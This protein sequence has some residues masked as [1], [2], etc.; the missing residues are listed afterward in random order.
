M[1][2][3][4]ARLFFVVVSYVCLAPSAASAS[5]ILFSIDRLDDFLIPAAEFGT[6]IEVEI[7]APGVT[8][9]AV[10][11][12]TLSV[13]MEQTDDGVWEEAG[14]NI[15]TSLAALESTVS[16][17][18]TIVVTG[19]ADA[20]TST[21][22]VNASGDLV[23]SDF[24]PTATGLSPAN[25]ATGVSA[26]TLLSWNPVPSAIVL[27]VF[28]EN[29]SDEVQEALSLVGEI[30]LN[31]SSWQPPL[32]LPTGAVEWGVFYAPDP[33]LTLDLLGNINVTNGSINWEVHEFADLAGIAWPSTKP[34]MLL[35]AESIVGITVPEPGGVLQGGV[36]LAMLGLL[37]SVRS[38][39]GHLGDTGARN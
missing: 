35:G 24:L 18:W 23:D 20:S 5:S 7:D 21:F 33:T 25:G 17:T 36:V 37:A 31:A 12:G 15:F 8:D 39:K 4:A 27:A 6:F 1:I 32:A 2:R 28:A 26:T 34:L 10:T 9:V 14:D 3:S 30:P 29:D 16:G 19:G 38:R 13:E 11:M 22:T